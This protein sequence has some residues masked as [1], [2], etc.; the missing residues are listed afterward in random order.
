MAIT[1]NFLQLKNEEGQSILE[2]VFMLPILFLFVS[3]LYR[4]NLAAHVAIN[5]IQYARSQ[6][7]LLT[8]NSPEYPR[9]S[10]REGTFVPQQQDRMLLGVSDP[11][12]LTSSN[13]NGTEME[14]IPQIQTIGRNNPTVK[15]SDE[16]GE[17]ANRT[18][19]RVRN[20]TAI[21]TQLNTA[22]TKTKSPMD[23]DHITAL[24]AQRWPF[25]QKVCQYFGDT[26][27]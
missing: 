11:S 12:A 16:R 9:L 17:V 25:K 27:L 5:N 22:D 24:Q 18:A 6:M 7:F 23:P 19:I 13:F 10:F 14:P 21:C 4:M 20:T 26:I 2:V 1:I 15:G 8:G 3:L